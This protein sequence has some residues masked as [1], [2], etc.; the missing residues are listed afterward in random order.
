[1]SNW[2]ANIDSTSKMTKYSLIFLLFSSVTHPCKDDCGKEFICS[3]ATGKMDN[4]L[5]IDRK[6]YHVWFIICVD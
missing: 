3:I 6:V 5:A 2:N 4:K 1:M